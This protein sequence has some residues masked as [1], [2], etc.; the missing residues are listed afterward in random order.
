MAST[1]PSRARASA[2]DTRPAAASSWKSPRQVAITRTVVPF[3]A[4]TFDI[5][6]SGD[7]PSHDTSTNNSRIYVRTPGKYEI[8]GQLQIVQNTAGYRAVQVRLN[9]AGS[10]TGGTQLI[11]NVEDASAAALVSMQIP[12][13]EVA[14]TAGDYV[15]AF[16][17][18]NSGTALNTIVGSGVSFL[19][20]K[21]SGS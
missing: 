3:A 15:E 18:Q 13:V 9:S 12:A 17:Q 14:L 2:G 4:E 10:A 7:S 6:Q 16:A 21:L 8:N 1:P 20:V 5:V 11:L 19:R